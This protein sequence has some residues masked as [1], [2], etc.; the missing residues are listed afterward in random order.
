METAHR[1][2]RVGDLGKLDAVETRRRIEQRERAGVAELFALDWTEFRRVEIEDARIAVRRRFP[3]ADDVGDFVDPLYRADWRA[4][5]ML[6]DY[7]AHAEGR[8]GVEKQLFCRLIEID[9][10]LCEVVRGSAGVVHRKSRAE[11]SAAPFGEEIIHGAC[12]IGLELFDHARARLHCRSLGGQRRYLIASH[13][14]AAED[15]RDD[16]LCRIAVGDRN[17]HSVNALE[18]LEFLLEDRKITG[19]AVR[20][21]AVL[22]PATHD[23]S[24]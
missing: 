2:V 14:F 7:G 22:S 20:R 9:A 12:T 24:P 10:A 6:R 3:I 16:L 5:V 8:A 11:Q 1:K 17:L 19:A 4:L 13:D 18:H 21:R 23:A 15:F